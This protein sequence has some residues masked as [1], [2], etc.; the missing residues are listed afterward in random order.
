MRILKK[1]LKKRQSTQEKQKQGTYGITLIA[2]VITVVVM[3]ILAGV[4]IS[5]L[6]DDGGLFGKTRGAAEAY[7]NSA[8]KEAKQIDDL[9]NNIDQYLAGIPTSKPKIDGSWNGTINA[10]KLATG[11]TAV[12]WNE[13]GQEIEL[14][15]SSSKS[16][17]NKWYSYTAQ[18][19]STATPGSGTSKWA[20]A[21]TKDENGNITGYW[22]WIPRYEYKLT[23]PASGESAGKIDVKFISTEKKTPSSS[24]YK[25]HPVFTNDTDKG[26]WDSELPGFWIAK[27]PAGYQKNTVNASG[28]IQNVGDTLVLSTLKY[29]DS[30]YTT[31]ALGQNVR[32]TSTAI[33]YPVFK[34]LT[35][36]YNC[37]NIDSMFRISQDIKNA[38][39]FYGLTTSTDSHLMKNSEW[40]AVAYLA[41]S[42]YGRNA[43]EPNINNVSVNNSS[44]YI[45]AV[46]GMAASGVDTST[47]SGFTGNIYST[48]VGQQGSTTG[49]ITGVYDMNGCV[50]E[51]VAAYIKNSQ[52]ATNRS[53]Y[54]ASLVASNVNPKHITIYPHDSSDGY[55]KNWA[56][57]DVATRYGDAMK[58][59]AT[60]AAGSYA[61]NKDNSYYPKNGEPFSMRGGSDYSGAGAGV[62]AFEDDSGSANSSIGF[63]VCLVFCE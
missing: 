63:R 43:T 30:S 39:A 44:K 53:T 21:V 27:Y 12:Y 57:N 33:S 51:Y 20:N 36:V 17:W 13:S 8:E 37:I 18:T 46:T 23:A 62:F 60:G 56:K 42:Q 49:N 1:A 40:G 16:E 11:M 29:T 28:T 2:L 58:E 5:V 10:P 15:S 19:G 31:N 45:Y 7:E 14:T 34:P 59:V 25:I 3:L 41:W 24:E 4:A 54:G 48:A 55:D 26:G 6:T 35:Y 50:W 47:S 9:M 61:W 32:S 22:V 52:G 38:T